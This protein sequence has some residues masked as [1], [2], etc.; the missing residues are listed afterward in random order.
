MGPLLA[1]DP[2]QVGGHR[3][4]GRL[5]EGGQG[6][7]YLAEAPGGR[8]VAVKVLGAGLDDPDARGRFRQE[9]ELARRVKAFCT[10]QVLDS[11]E[12]GGT[13]YVVS[14]FV[15][16][17]S[18]AQVIRERGALRGAELRRLAIGTLTA[19]AAIHRAGVVHRDFKPG[20]VLL[21]RDGPR[22]IDFG[23]SR[24]LEE[25][26]VTGDFLVGTPPY[27]AP[28]QFAGRQAGPPADLFA[29]ASTMMS[30]ATGSPPF[31]TGDVPAL[32]NRIMHDEPRLAGLDDD[33]LHELVARC[34]AKD[35]ATRPAATEALLSLLGHRVPERRL[36][37]EGQQLAAPPGRPLP[38]LGTPAGRAVPEPS[39]GR[40][41]PRLRRGWMLGGGALLMAAAV[42]VAVLL[43]RPTPAPP[44]P[45]AA[46]ASPPAPR[47]G[48]LALTS[49]SELKIPD[50]K[51]TLYE[52]PADPV[53]VSSY[54]DQRKNADF[55]SYVRDPA[56]GEFGFFGTLQEPLVSPGGGYVISLP[57]T[58]LRRADFEF[59]KLRDRVT[60][61]DEQIRTVDKPATLHRPMWSDDGRRLLASVYD[62]DQ[63]PSRLLGFALLDPVTRSFKVVKADDGGAGAYVWGSDGAS[64]LHG[65]PGG[66]VRVLGLDGR[67]LRTF[68]GVG[69]L[70][71]VSVAHTSI[72]T[73]FAT[74]CPDN[75]GN[76]CL[77]DEASGG[78]KG[79]IP[80]PKGRGFHGWLDGSHFLAT[81]R[82]GGNTDVVLMDRRGRVAR[83]LAD[84]PSTEID[85]VALWFTRK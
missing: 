22:V 64:V 81:V 47:P 15:D 18:L 5:G 79:V 68:S 53:W 44:A 73:V 78:K 75:G 71:E 51:I 76:I 80:L 9:I 49:T 25:A 63:K 84:G 40:R 48:P 50:T 6:L 28:E 19:L 61:R 17:P 16:G 33:E 52:N 36:L 62:P 29:W 1:G 46:A 45:P 77:W 3:I 38:P 42:T 83:K 7:V 70:L 60:G 27:M 32:I 31:G 21:S 57:G 8:R 2:A 56:T 74:T 55:S 26:E 34:L 10:A 37:A 13:P 58:R 24:A 12:I 30:A 23:I 43:A 39:A 59:I 35:P 41:W 85:R 82:R 66:A 20:N 54:H 14:E 11:G 69:E 4:L 65:A 72:G 67:L